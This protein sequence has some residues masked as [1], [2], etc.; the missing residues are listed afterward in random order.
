MFRSDKS[1]IFSLETVPIASYKSFAGA[2]EN[3]DKL[4]TNVL[5]VP[6]LPEEHD[7]FVNDS[8]MMS[9]N[10]AGQDAFAICLSDSATQDQSVRSQSFVL[11]QN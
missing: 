11:Q 10:E 5:N 7:T 4:P 8:L 6:N 1:Y 3:D 9:Q 2:N